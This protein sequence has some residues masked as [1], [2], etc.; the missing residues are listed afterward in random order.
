VDQLGHAERTLV[1]LDPVLHPAELDVTDYVI[2]VLQADPGS[3]R[4]VLGGRGVAGEIRARV[5]VA[6]HERVDV[7]AV[8]RDRGQFDAAEVV[9]DP[10]RLDHAPRAALDGLPVGLGRV[11][12]RERDVLHAVAVGAGE[13]GDLAVRAEAAR[14]HEPDAVLVEDVRGPV[15]DSSL[16]PRIRGLREPE[17]VLVEVRS[18]LRVADVELEVIPP[19]DRHEVGRAHESDLNRGRLSC[20]RVDR[21]FQT[22]SWPSH[23]S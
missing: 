18:L 7:L 2:D 3:G 12:D 4:A 11:R 21:S 20:N 14:D 6:I 1:E 22:D 9:L 5:V 8:G 23:A 15:P 19:L 17:R 16:R 10:V 13:A